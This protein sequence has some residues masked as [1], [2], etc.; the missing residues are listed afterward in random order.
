MV[1]L[2]PESISQTVFSWKNPD[3]VQTNFSKIAIVGVFP[4][5]E[6][7]STFENEIIQRLK[8]QGVNAIASI[9]VLSPN[10]KKRNADSEKVI[11]HLKSKG[12]DA[13]LMVTVSGMNQKKEYTTGSI[14]YAPTTYYGRFG[15]YYRTTYRKTW[16]P[17]YFRQERIFY[18]EAHLYGLS[19]G[20]LVWLFEYELS[21]PDSIKN[22]SKAY[23]KKLVRAAKKDDVLIIR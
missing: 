8:K 9:D 21:N 20:H 19:E 16:S 18:L 15:Q 2:S 14:S 11:K 12:Y 22:A 3:T 5:E 10:L 4:K 1:F 17:G 7:K 23:A 6:L 13:V